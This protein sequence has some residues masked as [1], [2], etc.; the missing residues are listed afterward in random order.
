MRK[1]NYHHTALTKGYV[2]IKNAEGIKESY[3][4]K[5]GTGYT[6]KRYNP[7]STRYCLIDY[8]VAQSTA[9]TL[10]GASTAGRSPGADA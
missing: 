4:G 3:S 1:Y 5:F 7:N 9:E 8:Y 6:I 2:S 10:F